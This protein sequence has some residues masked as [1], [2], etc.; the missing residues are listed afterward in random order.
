MTI[1]LMEE[2]GFKATCKRIAGVTE[3]LAED[4]HSAG[5][6]ALHQVN[7]HGN[8]NFVTALIEAMGRKHRA[9]AVKTWLMHFG[10]VQFKKGEVKVRN[11]KDLTAENAEAWLEKANATPFWE[12][13][14]EPVA[15]LHK[16]Y[17][18]AIKA[19]IH[20][21]TETVKE[22]VAAGIQVTEENTGIVAQLEKIVAAHK[23]ANEADKEIVSIPAKAIVHEL[24]V[25]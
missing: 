2:K 12:L 23:P 17:L 4:I 24:K 5:L 7:V 20:F 3:K 11:R 21:H 14:P 6:F 25:A 15:K 8:T 10:R 1:K 19:L 22:K 18:T 16:D 9:E 13:T